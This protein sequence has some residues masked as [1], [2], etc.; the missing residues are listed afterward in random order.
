MGTLS[1]DEA[2]A[3]YI[4]V[5]TENSRKKRASTQ[6]AGS[7]CCVIKINFIQLNKLQVISKISFTFLGFGLAF[8]YLHMKI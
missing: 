8:K 6:I 4:Q 3:E 5:A 1:V 2:L 7:D